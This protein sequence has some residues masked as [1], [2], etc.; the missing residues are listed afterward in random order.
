MESVES[1]NWGLELRCLTSPP[2]A[3]QKEADAVHGIVVSAGTV[4]V[5]FKTVKTMIAAFVFLY[6]IVFNVRFVLG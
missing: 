3:L 2:E 5:W 6:Q 4:Q 1:F